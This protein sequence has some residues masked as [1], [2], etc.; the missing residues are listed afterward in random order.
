LPESIEIGL[1]LVESERQEL[2]I[3]KLERNR[4]DERDQG[5]IILFLTDGC[6]TIK[7]AA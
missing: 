6:Q 2:L 5:N 3:L 4:L 7:L 1:G